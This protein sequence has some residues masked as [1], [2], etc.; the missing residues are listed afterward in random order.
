MRLFQSSYSGKVVKY[1]L[2]LQFLQSD[3][4]GTHLNEC[5]LRE[6]CV[7]LPCR[8][9]ATLSTNIRQLQVKAFQS[10]N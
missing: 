3:L 5:F 2:F 6:M 8:Q 10:H 9:H 1:F 7:D 4:E